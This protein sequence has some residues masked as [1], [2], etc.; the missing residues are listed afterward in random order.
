MYSSGAFLLQSCVFQQSS[1]MQSALMTA[2]SWK[3]LLLLSPSETAFSF[4]GVCLVRQTRREVLIEE[5]FDMARELRDKLRDGLSAS[6]SQPDPDEGTVQRMSWES[7]SNA[8]DRMIGFMFKPLEEVLNINRRLLSFPTPENLNGGNTIQDRILAQD[9]V[10]QQI[11][12]TD[13]IGT[14]TAG[15]LYLM[16]KIEKTT[17]ASITILY[18]GERFEEWLKKDDGKRLA[19]ILCG[20]GETRERAWELI[21]ERLVSNTVLW[22]TV[23]GPARELLLCETSS[24]LPITRA[25]LGVSRA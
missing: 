23:L 5:A 15:Y 19:A 8:I 12:R 21:D 18:V 7:I 1:V 25:R 13:R 20:S 6:T 2:P 24:R 9:L 4:A 14:F 22:R 11:I 3:R 16:L 17:S 10:W